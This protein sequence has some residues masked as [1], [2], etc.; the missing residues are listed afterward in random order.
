MLGIVG[1]DGI[2]DIEDRVAEVTDKVVLPRMLPEVAEMI[3]VPAAT[4][5]ARPPL[6]TVATAVFDER[7]VTCVVMTWL[8]PSEYVPVAVNCWV[9]PRVKLGVAG[10]TTM[11]ARVAE[12]IV[13]VAAPEALPEKASMV[14]VPAA[15][16]MARPL[17]LTVA[18]EVLEVPQVTC[19]VISLLDPSE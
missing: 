7:Q 15:T 5:V 18:T 17:P 16:A 1:L 9:I 19:V 10:V 2:T 14:A 6:S 8:V 12:L 4:A 13:K 3:A 11:D